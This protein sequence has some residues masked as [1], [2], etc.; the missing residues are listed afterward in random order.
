M[1]TDTWDDTIGDMLNWVAS[2]CVL[3][4]TGVTVVDYIRYFIVEAYIF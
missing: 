2:P 1:G 4:D 3:S